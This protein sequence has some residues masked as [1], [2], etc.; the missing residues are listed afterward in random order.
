[1]I[2]EAQTLVEG[3]GSGELL[4]LDE[5]LSFWGGLRADDGEIIDHRH[6]QRGSVVTGRILVMP[7][8]RGSSSSSSILVEAVRA[9]T[10][11]SAIVLAEPDAIVALGA[12]VADELYDA[13]LPVVVAD[14]A[15]FQLLRTGARSLVTAGPQGAT[16]EAR[17][18]G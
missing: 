14:E 1:M 6:P 16:I 12:I 4:V 9:G 7:A 10:A 2:T 13:K 17:G 8:G 3:A 18:E 15:A 11:P 5:P